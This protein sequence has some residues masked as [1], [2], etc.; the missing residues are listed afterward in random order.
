MHGA[1]RPLGWLAVTLLAACDEP[2]PERSRD[3]APMTASESS[4]AAPPAERSTARKASAPE[5][6]GPSSAAEPEAASERTWTR[7]SHPT[8]IRGAEVIPPGTP[9]RNAAAFRKLAV[10]PGDG[11]P[12]GGIGAGGIHLDELEVGHGWVKSR[13]SERAD[14]FTIGVQDRVN[15]CMRVVHER[16]TATELGI[17]WLREGRQARRSK[18]SIGDMHALLT[19]AYLPISAGY[20]G[21]WQ[22]RVVAVDGTVIGEVSFRVVAR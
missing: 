1:V 3:A 20:E 21:E 6:A 8:D 5:R 15:V 16:G 10:L 18:V 12:L 4:V 22:A 14:V 11:P 13:C 2:L 17:E 9:E 19:R 7:P